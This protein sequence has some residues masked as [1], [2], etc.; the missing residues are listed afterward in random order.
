MAGLGLVWAAWTYC[1]A[2]AYSLAQ[3]SVAAPFE[4]LSL[5]INLFWGL[6][7]FQGIP[8]LTMLA[9]AVLTVLSGIYI[10]YLDRKVHLKAV[11]M[12]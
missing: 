11:D 8:M 2:R 6:L 3:A 10:L 7:I 9:G 12:A 5:P 1:M 4:Y